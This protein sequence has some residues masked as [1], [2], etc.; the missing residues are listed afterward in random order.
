MNLK[1]ILFVVGPTAVG[2][3]DVAVCLA[4]HFNTEII[5]CDAMQ[6]Y[7][8]I[9]IA[10]NKPSD[11]VLRQIPHHLI[12]FI[13]VTEE[14]DV[15][16]FRQEV[17]KVVDKLHAQGKVPV[18]VGG[19]GLY[20][21]VLADGIFEGG[22]KNEELRR[23]FEAQVL[24]EGNEKLY[25][26]LVEVD[27]AAAAKIHVHDTRRIIRALEVFHSRQKPISQLQPE[28]EGLF[29]HYAVKVYVLTMPRAELYRRINERVEEMF[30][31]GLVEEVRKL[32]HLLLSPTAQ[33]MIGIPEVQGYLRGDYDLER[34]K[35]LMKLN[36]RHLAKRQLT[37]F[38]KDKRFHWITIGSGDGAQTVAEEILK[39]F[40]V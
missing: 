33:R 6:V 15:F 37:W 30:A 13:P 32:E 17:S 14:S 40:G 11:A 3:T 22:E 23:Q 26:Q 36:T 34:A 31:Q 5:S 2:K 9:S 25:A 28:R 12:S 18:I 39:D 10:S 4:R 1:K 16:T 7:K 35:Y 29:D 38:R 19:S 21:Q 27:P 8:E 24:K 20:M